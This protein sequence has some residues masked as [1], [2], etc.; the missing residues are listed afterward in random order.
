VL[1]DACIVV[2]FSYTLTL[3]RPAEAL[4]K[5]RPTARLLGVETIVSVVGMI[6]VNIA[7]AVASMA[8]LFG[9]VSC[10]FSLKKP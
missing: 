4:A 10:R 9:Q 2:S 7:F 3:S 6:L 8:L 5:S 1:V